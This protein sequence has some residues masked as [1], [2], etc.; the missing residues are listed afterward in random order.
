MLVFGSQVIAVIL[1]VFLHHGNGRAI[2]SISNE[3]ID[4]I[5][6]LAEEEFNT[7][8]NETSENP[9]EGG[10]NPA[11]VLTLSEV[12]QFQ[13]S[14]DVSG[15]SANKGPSNVILPIEANPVW[16]HKR[17]LA[18]EPECYTGNRKT[19]RLTHTNI[20]ITYPECRKVAQ[21]TACSSSMANNNNKRKCVESNY[22]VYL[23][24][25]VII[26]TKCSCAP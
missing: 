7:V 8:F 14:D 17:S 10:E 20:T 3:N 16:R 5:L 26:P 15:E 22:V 6:D 1:A 9:T 13:F 19:I 25:N 4:S 12:V 21:F 23:K 2:T 24:D 11:D 18:D